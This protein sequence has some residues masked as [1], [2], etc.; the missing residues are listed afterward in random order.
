MAH[1]I[2][3]SFSLPNQVTSPQDVGQ[4]VRELEKINGE[5]EQAALRKGGQASTSLSKPGR[6]LTELCEENDLNLLHADDRQKLQKALAAV[7]EHAPHMHISFSSEPPSAFLQKL[8]DWLRQEIHP[9]VLVSVGLQPSIGAGC[10][11][12]T[13]NKYFDFGL[14]QRF[15]AKR[16][17]LIEKLQAVNG[18]KA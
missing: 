4:L 18:V 1:E 10:T 11:L 12:R 8:L 3:T 14:R 15:D 6:L 17:V 5:L 2:K 16:E 13:N 9:Y 7:K